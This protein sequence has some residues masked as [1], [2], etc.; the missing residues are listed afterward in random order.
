MANRKNVL[1]LFKDSGRAA[2]AIRTLKGSGWGLDRVHSPFPEHGIMA[3]LGLKKSRVGYFTLAGGIFGFFFGFSLAIFTATRWD[4]I[5]S[6]KPVVAL[7]PFIIV[8]FECTIL[9]SVLGNILGFLTQAR[10]P[11][12]KGLEGHEPKCTGDHFGI[13]ATCPEGEEGKLMEFFHEQGGE[14]RLLDENRDLARESRIEE[15]TGKMG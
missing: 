2:S 8:G 3:A 7:I 13:V 6:G 12:F 11:D 10:L 15:G 14:G 4:L 1:G 9:F 5:V